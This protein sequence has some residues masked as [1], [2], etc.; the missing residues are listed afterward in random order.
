MERVLEILAR[1]SCICLDKTFEIRAS[2]DDK[3]SLTFPNGDVKGRIYLQAHYVSKCTKTG[4]EEEWK[5]RK[6][7]LSDHMTDDEIIK[8]AYVTFKQAVEHEVMEGFKVDNTI[9]FN[10][11]VNFEALLQ[12]SNQEVKREEKS[13]LK[14]V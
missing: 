8:T 4:V 9:L 7:Y 1:I 6:N 11:H 10:P 12:I 2:Y 5:G 14:I 3:Y 13:P